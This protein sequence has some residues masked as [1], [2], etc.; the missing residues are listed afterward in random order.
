MTSLGS[1]T[2]AAQG[3]ADQLPVFP[4]TPSVKHEVQDRPE[5]GEG[6]KKADD[7]LAR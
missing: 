3:L 6:D 7:G 4:G 2:A 5:K 1:S